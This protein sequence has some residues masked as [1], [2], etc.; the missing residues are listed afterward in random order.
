MRAPTKIAREAVRI[1]REVGLTVTEI[2]QNRRHTEV[3]VA[4][5]GE[6]RGC[7]RIHQGSKVNDRNSSRLRGQAR[8]LI[9]GTAKS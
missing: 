8:G 4:F 6:P 9:R 7:L 5:N 2:V 3:R 1:A